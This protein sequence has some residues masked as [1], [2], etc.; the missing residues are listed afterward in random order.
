M[1]KAL[2]Q[3]EDENQM[4]GE[5]ELNSNI[6]VK[7]LIRYIWQCNCSRYN[8]QKY[9]VVIQH[10]LCNLLKLRAIKQLKEKVPN[11]RKDGAGQ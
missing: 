1:E 11:Y 2:S 5:V 7:K 10:S 6:H 3:W 4:Y 9:T 8:I